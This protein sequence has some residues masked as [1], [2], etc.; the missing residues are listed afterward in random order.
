MNWG[1]ELWDRYDSVVSQV[2]QST[3]ELDSWYGNFFKERSKIENEYARSLRKL[4]KTY[5]P[6][7]KK[8]N[9]EDESTQ[10][11]GFRLILQELGYQAGQHE[12]LADSYGKD[13]SKAIDDRLKEV[14]NEM[15][16]NKKEAESIEKNV[17]QTYKSLDSKKQKYQKAHVEL[18]VTMN[19]FKKTESD[20]T[21]SRAE[22]DKMRAM[23]NKKTRESDDTKAQYAHQLIQTN[24]S[25]QEYYYKLLPA[26]LNN[27]Q[28][29][30]IGNCEFFKNIINKCVKKEKDVAPIVTKCH[31]EMGNVI[32]TINAKQDS[33]IV[34]NRLKTGN[35]PPIDFLF[36]E[37]MPGMEVNSNTEKRNTMSRGRSKQALNAEKGNV[38]YF[39]RKRELQKK[40]EA[41]ESDVLKG[42][43]EMKSLQLMIQTYT[44]NPKFGDAKQFQG[45]LDAAAHKVQLLESELHAMQTELVDVNNTLENIKNQSPS[46]N[47]IRREKSPSGSLASSLLSAQV[48]VSSTTDSLDSGQESRKHQGLDS[49]IYLTGNTMGQTSEWEEDV[50]DDLSTPLP[51][52][53]LEKVVALYQF[54]SDSA[55]TIPMAEREEFLIIEDDQDGW[56]KVKRI[57]NRF[58][59]DVGEGFVPTSFI[60]SL[61]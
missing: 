46:I 9:R 28:S 26:I 53:D 17:S 58:F 56:T 36:E 23:S 60:Q 14:K 39:Q 48:S 1:D 22:V 34:I 40:I 7:E 57:D 54:E 21:I 52:E 38:N 42:Q 11:S 47:Q 32:G 15:K 45:E 33:E 31:E 29:L 27:L 59:D 20:G 2:S 10:T 18:E 25:Q 30:E 37:L 41:Q 49:G 6:K 55:D 50:Y 12:L 44:Q 43:K 8:K 35:V 4:I 24:K 19:T 13:C 51:S 16:K 5:S 3:R 61:K